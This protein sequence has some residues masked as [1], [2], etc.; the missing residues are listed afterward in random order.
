MMRKRLIAKFMLP[1][2]CIVVLVMFVVGGITDHALESQVRE[3]ANGEAVSGADQLLD[4][5]ATIDSLS[6]ES[7]RSAMKVLIR[8]AQH[9]GAPEIKGTATVAGQVVPDLRLGDSSQVGDFT[10][11]DRIK[12]LTGNTATLFVRQGSSYVRVSTNVLKADGSRAVGTVLDPQGHAYAAI[13]E[14]RPFLGVVDIL[15]MPYMTSY[16]PMRDK[17]GQ[18]V[19]VWYVGA[20]LA[21]V[22]N[23]GKHISTA[24]IL[25]RGFIALVHANGK[26][27]FKPDQVREEDVQTRLKTG[28]G[29]GWTVISRPFEKWGYTLLTTYPDSD[30]SSQLRQMQL[31]VAICALL[32]AG[33]VVFVLYLLVNRLI[34]NPL[35]QVIRAAE[36][37]ANGD[38]RDEIAVTSEDET[39]KLQTSMKKMS[40]SLSQMITEV[41]MGATALSSAS[42]QVASSAQSISQGTSEQ[43]ASVEETTASLEEMGASI[44]QNAENSRQME[45]MA[46]KGAKDAEESGKA[47]RE[48]VAVMKTIAQ[49]TSIIQEIAFQTNLLALNAAIEAARAGEHGKGFAVVATEVRKLAERSQAAAKEISEVAASSVSVAETSGQLLSELVPSIQ[50][51][52]ELVQEVAAASREQSSG[53]SQIN[54]A[55]GQV[56]QVTQ[57]NSAASEELAGTAEELAAQ[58]EAL[59]QTMDFFKLRASHEQGAP[60]QP[61]YRGSQAAAVPNWPF[62]PQSQVPSSA[63]LRAQH[64]TDTRHS[65]AND[66][67]ASNGDELVGTH[68]RRF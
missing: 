59:K 26:V 36:N 1:M 67:T 44:G 22:A 15:G 11:V 5:L 16:E 34:L 52:T 24:K 2:V 43:A 9:S 6:S 35:V 4:T 61:V 55:M 49:K 30:I 21:S 7:V 45:Q 12:D 20:P 60:F 13:Q 68:F 58:A 10:L 63:V 17:S 23:L 40:E 65:G 31:L 57:R 54:K 51:T 48:T 42:S 33:L 27:I 14:Q 3:R 39:G 41:R 46:L 38:L 64:S 29:A 28:T 18:I 25:E 8:E 53:V 37:I 62:A 32:M 66:A 50:K 47:V 19:G 56:D